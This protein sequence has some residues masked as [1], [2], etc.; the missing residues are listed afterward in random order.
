[1]ININ[2]Y[3]PSASIDESAILSSFAGI[4]PLVRDETSNDPGST[5]REH[6]IYMPGENIFV[7]IGGKY[8]TFRTMGQEISR[9][10]C[11]RQDIAYNSDLS[12]T[13]LT[14]RSIPKAFSTEQI[15]TD[16]LQYIKDNYY[17]KTLEDMYR[18]CPNVDKKSIQN[19]YNF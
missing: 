14:F 18:R 2:E 8:T 5:C 9:T 19:F 12:K 3:F 10:I 17:V 6:Q 1:M 16:Q 7:I 13:K 4:R 15:S 11:L